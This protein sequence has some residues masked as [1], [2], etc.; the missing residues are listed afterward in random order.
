MSGAAI[1][2]ACS[3]LGG[4]RQFLQPPQDKVSS[5]KKNIHLFLHIQRSA[6]ILLV[7]GDDY[8]GWEA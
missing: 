8:F 5:V 6:H 4:S 2:G 1:R 7:V 3:P